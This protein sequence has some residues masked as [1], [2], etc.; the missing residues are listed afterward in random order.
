MLPHVQEHVTGGMET[1]S[2]FFLTFFTYIFQSAL[3]KGGEG[4]KNER[5]G[6]SVCVSVLALLG[7]SFFAPKTLG[8][9]WVLE[10]EVGEKGEKEMGQAWE[11]FSGLVS[12]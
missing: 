7:A 9:V 6:A 11:L 8:Q 12:E 10:R 5:G 4:R 1:G 3:K 2:L